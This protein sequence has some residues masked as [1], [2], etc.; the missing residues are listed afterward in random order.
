MSVKSDGWIQRMALQKRM[1]DPFEA[2]LVRAGISFGLSSYG[3]DFRLSNIFKIYEPQPGDVVDPK[4]FDCLVFQE[5]HGDY[6]EIPPQ[7]F[8][9]GQSLEYFRIPRNILTI[10]LGKS[11]YAR[12]GIY[13]HVT[14]LEPE[15]EGFITVSIFN[16]TPRPAR[17]YAGEGIGQLVFVEADEI[18]QVSYADR[19]G[20]YQAQKG[21]T[22]ALI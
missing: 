4:H 16:A 14:P 7:T 15:W 21:V 19:A 10:C 5:L 17:V 13:V 22:G 8:V 9:L 1:I 20:K 18:C 2:S 11:T 12:C 3:Y 6:C